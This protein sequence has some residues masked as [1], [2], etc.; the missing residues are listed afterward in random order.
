MKQLN[1]R[2]KQQQKARN[3]LTRPT[4]KSAM[5]NYRVYYYA[6][7]RL[8]DGE[9]TLVRRSRKIKARD[10]NEAEA[11]VRHIVKASIAQFDRTILLPE[12]EE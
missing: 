4:R 11:K 12:S 3:S 10:A 5:N 7:K 1:S 6:R 2:S 8:K 9:I